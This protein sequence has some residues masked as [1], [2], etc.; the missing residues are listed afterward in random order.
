MATRSVK[1][2]AVVVVMLALVAGGFYYYAAYGL[3]FATKVPVLGAS[4]QAPD[5]L[6]IF[7]GC[8]H[9]AS[10]TAMED[11]T[12]VTIHAKLKIRPGGDCAT[13]AD[14]ELDSPLGERTLIDGYDGQEISVSG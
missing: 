3:P 12:T 8:G 7:M 4:L 13:S 11:G 6:S 9:D 5:Q 14:V 2:T 10:A 1:W